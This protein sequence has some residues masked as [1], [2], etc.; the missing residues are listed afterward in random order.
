MSRGGWIM[1]IGGVVLL[2]GI[3][4]LAFGT[5]SFL[6]Q[7]APDRVALAT[8]AYQNHTVDVV[9]IGSALTY[10]VGIEDFTLGDELTVFIQT[11]S[12]GEAQ[13]ATVTTGTLTT[14]FVTS[15]LGLHTLVIQNTGLRTVTII[16]AVS[17]IDIL[18][19]SLVATGIFLGIGGFIVFIVGLVLWIVARGRQRR[20]PMEMPPPPP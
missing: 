10:V 14:S 16:H 12:G 6:S 9:E 2:V 13:R 19:A 17:V 20:Q 8:D 7:F 15:E 11:P 18:A 1:I 3:G 4:L 5:A